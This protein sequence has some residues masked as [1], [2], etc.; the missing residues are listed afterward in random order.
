MAGVSESAF[1]S[2]V[3]RQDCVVVEGDLDY[4]YVLPGVPVRRVVSLRSA[5]GTSVVVSLVE[6]PER[7]EI[8]PQQFTLEAGASQE[9][10]VEFEERR[11]GGYSGNVVFNCEVGQERGRV[12]VR[13]SALTVPAFIERVPVQIG[14]GRIEFHLHAPADSRVVLEQSQDL[15]RWEPVAELHFPH[16]NLVFRQEVR[17]HSAPCFYR[18][19]MAASA[20]GDNPAPQ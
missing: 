19:A 9:V 5:C 1:L 16:T 2:L 20:V 12:M 13:A 7:F 3:V 17:T 14:G 15:V 4:G 18:L 10:S 11:E 6:C 8:T